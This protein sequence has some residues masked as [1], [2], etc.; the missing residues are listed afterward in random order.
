[1][2]ATMN[3]SL[4]WPIKWVEATSRK[5]Q[6]AHILFWRVVGLGFGALPLCEIVDFY[7]L[8]FDRLLSSYVQS[9]VSSAWVIREFQL[10]VLGI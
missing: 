2:H 9:N 6:V 7:C 8:F 10:D 4:T 3:L 1:M 5:S